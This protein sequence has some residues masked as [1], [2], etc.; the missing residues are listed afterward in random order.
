MHPE[1]VSVDLARSRYFSLCS[2]SVAIG[3]VLGATAWCSIAVSVAL[4]GQAPL[5]S[6]FAGGL[7][8]AVAGAPLGAVAGLAV[9]LAILGW[10]GYDKPTLISAQ[11]V[12]L[13]LSIALWVAFESVNSSP[14]AQTWRMLPITGQL[15]LSVAGLAVLTWGF[16]RRFGTTQTSA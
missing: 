5:R 11:I 12:L 16:Q 2:L 6:V 8:G 15:V 4:D 10:T 7:D 14:T 9:G 1:S 13:G 3:A